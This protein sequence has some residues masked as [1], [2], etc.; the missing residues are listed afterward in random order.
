VS[1]KQQADTQA[2][3]CANRR[4]RIPEIADDSLS[5]RGALAEKFDHPLH[6]KLGWCAR[7]ILQVDRW[8]RMSSL[9]TGFRILVQPASQNFTAVL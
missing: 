7:T 4:S 8:H 6:R 3:A 2:E 5:C 1:S 9:R